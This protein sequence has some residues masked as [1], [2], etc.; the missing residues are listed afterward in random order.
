MAVE[1]IVIGREPE[2]FKAYGKKGCIFLGKHVVGKGLDFHLTNPILMD[3]LRPHVV[4]I[5]G[6]RGC[7]P[8]NHLIFT[9]NGYKPIKE[10]KNEEDVLS[11]NMETLATEWKKAKLVKY[12]VDDNEELFKFILEDGKE[13]ITTSEHP[14]LTFH[15]DIVLVWKKACNIKENEKLI[16]LI[17][18]PE[19][20]NDKEGLRIARLL[21]LI[22]ADGTIGIKKGRYKDG[23]GYWYNGTKKRIRITNSHEK[24]LNQA[25]KDFEE[26]FVVK[27]RIDKRKKENC[28]DVL[29]TNSKV[30][31]KF[32]ELGV[33]PGKKARTMTM[34]KIVWESSDK[35]KSEFLK[36]LFSCDGYIQKNGGRVEYYTASKQFA[37]E[38]QLLLSHFSI[39]SV[40]RIKN[41]LYG[42]YYKVGFSD[43]ESLKNFKEKIGFMRDDKNARLIKKFCRRRRKVKT[44]YLNDNLSCRKIVKIEKM[45]NINEVFDLVVDD[46]HSFIANGIVSHNSGKSY[47]S[48]VMAEEITKLPD[49]VRQNLSCLMVDTMGIFW[50]MKN[51]ND[52]QLMDLTEWN[53]KPKGFDIKIIIPVGIKSYYEK[54]G[55]SY[56]GIFAIKP[57][58]LSATD[59]ALTFNID[60]LDPLGILLE[61]IIKKLKG[62]DCS[63]D[64]IIN[65]IENDKRSDEK[66]KLSLENKFLSARDWGIFS[67]GAV[68]IENFLEPGV[69][70]VL[71]VSLQDTNVR[72]LMIGIL[73]REVYQAR[74]SS[75]RI[76]EMSLMGGEV[77][78]R[79]PMTWIIIDEVHEYL[80]EKGATAA[81]YDLLTLLRQGRQPGVSL[82]LIT[83]RPNK[84][85]E[86]AISQADLIVAHRLT[87]KPD[88]EALSAI[89]QTY[90]LSDIRKL[91]QELPKNKGAA[92]I[93][94][95]NSE[96]IF[97]IQVRP[98]QSW[99]AGESPV[100]L[101][102]KGS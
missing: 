6:K 31:D 47:T 30:I 44:I 71:D 16:N 5:T 97:N 99:H 15:N 8:G 102:E 89:M 61:R 74:M 64:D 78:K 42:K 75:R 62:K 76:E 7:L 25:K 14:L 54:Y 77:V 88:V 94:D 92:L 9:S 68:S 26:E 58:E 98:R 86:D 95:D 35:F 100:A 28:S 50:S 43:F 33:I 24:I 18:L 11:L 46:N 38:L 60:I 29:V 27:A 12:D 69:I 101:K 23:R 48:A 80:P 63:I 10:F 57:S 34:P 93:L 21:G 81:T 67:Q 17:S 96:R 51:P 1:D 4:L 36:A 56:D 79:V 13:I 87:A 40:I 3:V 72:S 83:Q 73:C 22:M 91:M 20:K 65:E 66:E 19:V 41:S 59:W 32:V 37:E 84:I 70:S 39:E 82:V 53:M 90:L 49:E 45:K 2:D 85:H 52:R 55:I